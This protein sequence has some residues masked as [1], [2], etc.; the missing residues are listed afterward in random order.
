MGKNRIAAVLL[1]SLLAV[2]CAAQAQDPAGRILW[3]FGQ[4]ERVAPDGATKTLAKGDPVFQ[5]DVLRSAPNSHA[6]LVMSDE[7]LVAVRPESSLRL[8]TYSYQGREDGTERAV[9][10]LLK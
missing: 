2:P 9:I 6:Q 8:D 5:G 3:V 4:V 7:A 1:G 10:E